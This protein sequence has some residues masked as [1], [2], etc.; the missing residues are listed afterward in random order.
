MARNKFDPNE[1]IE[2]SD[3]AEIILYDRD[4]NEKARTKIDLARVPDIVGTK[5]Y[6]KDNGYVATNNYRG[7][8]YTYL[9]I[10][11]AGNNTKNRY[12]D[13]IDGNKLNNKACNLRIVTPEQSGMNKG[14]RSDNKSGRTGVHW[15]KD[16][17]KWC[18]MICY[19]QR[20]VNL[21]Y[22]QTYVEAVNRREAAEKEFFG[23]YMPDNTRSNKKIS[24]DSI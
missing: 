23:Q 21:G 4:N 14:I 3:Y 8:G 20:H 17:Q 6:L 5:W 7:N 9:H 12:V 11:I 24:F 18:V 13:H 10:L 16:K 19:N 22:F 15:S 1:I 2:Y